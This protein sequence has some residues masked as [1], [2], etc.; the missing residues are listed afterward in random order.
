[1]NRA[2]L[3]KVHCMLSN[4]GLEK[5]FWSEA[6]AYT[7]HLISKLP[8]SGLGG[9]TPLKVWSKKVAQDYNSLLVFD[10]M[11][12]YHV[13]EEKLGLGARKGVFVDFKKSVEDYKIWDLKHKKIILSRDVT[14][15]HIFAKGKLTIKR[16]EEL[17]Y[18]YSKRL[19]VDLLR[20]SG[21][22]CR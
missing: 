7:C 13:K 10:S 9:K 19:Q 22:V 17:N 18:R 15:F 20:D 11:A 21:E 8:S 4:I 14:V 3:E 1:M 5:S 6:L 12:H 2:L 16:V